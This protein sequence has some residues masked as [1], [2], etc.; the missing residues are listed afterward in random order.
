MA[1]GTGERRRCGWLGM[2]VLLLG[3]PVAAS[4]WAQDGAPNGALGGPPEL[5][6][7]LSE[8]A[9]EM[10]VTVDELSA[11]TMVQAGQPISAR[12]KAEAILKEHPDSF[13][14][15]LVVGQVL[16]EAEASYPRA[17]FHLERALALFEA[18]HGPEPAPDQPWRFHAALLAQL[19]ETHGDLEHH[20]ERLAY[21][22]RFNDLYDPDM[23]AEQAWT[24]MKLGR[25][26]EARL[27]AQQGLSLSDRPAQRMIALNALC[28][29]EFEAG[30]DGASYDACRRAVDDARDSERV[31]SAVDLTNLA[32]AARS[33]FRLDEAERLAMEAAEAPVSFYGNPWLDLAELYTRQGR[34]PEALAALKEIP[35]YRARRPAETRA[36]DQ[37][38]IR[39]AV[40]AFLVTLS[41]AEDA[42]AITAQALVRPDRRAHQ[43]RDEVQ[44]GVVVALL[45][46]AARRLKVQLALEDA[47]AEP[48]YRRLWQRCMGVGE[49]LAA[50]HSGRLAA[51][52]LGDAQTLVGTFRV[53]TASAAIMPP[54]L[55]GEL[56]PVLGPGVVE[57]AVGEARAGDRRPGAAGYYDAVLAEV[58]LAQGEDRRALDTARE[59]LGALGASEQLLR[60][61]V[62]AV[63][64]RAAWELGLWSEARQAYEAAFQA[65]PGVLRR[66]E[67]AVPV[68][69]EVQG[70][71]AEDLAAALLASPRF[72]E[73][74]EGLRLQV[75]DRGPLPGACLYGRGDAVIACSEPSPPLAERQP[76]AGEPVEPVALVAASLHEE[77]F[78]P[79]VELTAADLNSL[80]GSNLVGREALE[81]ALSE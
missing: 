16:H 43:S 65:D 47:G 42:E 25:H 79:R 21:I 41:R 40:S 39:R 64:A 53:G 27:A 13:V 78:A 31:V 67:L 5:D 24:L 2:G 52:L 58:Y 36:A 63:E 61:R 38:E 46:R 68:R 62:A 55:L 37:N 6:D 28:A 11:Y 50:W 14:A 72:E 8:Q 66:L 70:D 80:D 57:V 45:D 59:A 22:S 35:A 81:E 73:D 3:L 19:A 9:G 44:D 32:E 51:R 54:W 74:Q 12:E 76:A 49:R 69:V 7:L 26:Q 23:V 10:G 18:T 29:I 56:V 34:F 1:G 60:G 75:Q 33:L 48:W 30:D 77:A 15:H 71:R 4:S 20:R 17:L